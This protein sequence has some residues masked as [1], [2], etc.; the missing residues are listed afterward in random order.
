MPWIFTPSVRVGPSVGLWAYL[1]LTFFF[2]VPGLQS[3]FWRS[4]Q[5]VSPIPF[6]M[7]NGS[8]KSCPVVTLCL[9]S[10]CV[11]SP[12]RHLSLPPPTPA[13]RA[14]FKYSSS[15]VAVVVVS[16]DLALS[17]AHHERR[18]EGRKEGEGAS[19]NLK[20]LSSMNEAATS[21]FLPR[22]P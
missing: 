13:N 16:A 11:Q 2:V 9:L 21:F 8:L 12:P 1:Q 6:S 14:Q 19:L 4:P 10:P 20:D 17:L 18:E 22:N 3:Q 15:S 5:G 7:A